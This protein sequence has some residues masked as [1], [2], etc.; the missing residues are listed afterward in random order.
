MKG[1][2]QSPLFPPTA[3]HG[4]ERESTGRN[5]EIGHSRL[6]PCTK[7]QGERYTFRRDG[8]NLFCVSHTEKPDFSMEERRNRRDG[9]HTEKV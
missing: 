2:A 8:A 3:C 6:H 1:L 7:K 5:R 4:R 9:L